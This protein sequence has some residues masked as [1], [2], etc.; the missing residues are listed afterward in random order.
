MT[1]LRHRMVEDMELRGLSPKTQQAYV[2][3]VKSLAGY[4]HRSPDKLSDEEIRRYFLYLVKEKRVALSTFRIQLCG[5]KLFYEKTLGRE[6]PVFKLVRPK[7]SRK[8]PAVLGPEEVRQ[9]LGLVRKPNLR[10]A[11]TVIYSCGLRLREGATLRVRDIDHERMVVCVRNGK[12]AKDRYVPLPERTWA[13]LAAH[14]KTRRPNS[15]LFAGK[16]EGNYVSPSTIQK[17]FKIALARSDISKDATVHTLRHSFAT[18]L[19][20][21]GVNLRVIQEVLGHQSLKTTARYTHLTSRSL[22]G[23]YAAVNHLMA[24][25]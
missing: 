12:G 2:W 25:L 21:S 24:G 1:E 15:W 3:A 9:I 11:L 16:R 19:L 14:M 23:L 22:G 8:L 20:E 17:A 6:L 18:H 10:M 4:Y 5:I 13:L 7:K